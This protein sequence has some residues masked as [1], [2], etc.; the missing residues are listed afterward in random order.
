MKNI[1]V[2]ASGGNVTHTNNHLCCAE[3]RVI[4]ELEYNAKKSGHKGKKKGVWIRR[5]TGGVI[6]VWRFSSDGQYANAF[7]CKVCMKSIVNYGLKLQCS[8]GPDLWYKGICPPRG[9]NT[10]EDVASLDVP[11]SKLTN[12][13]R[14]YFEG[15]RCKGL[16]SLE[17]P[18]L[19]GLHR[20]RADDLKRTAYPL[21]LKYH[22]G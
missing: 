6:R 1:I 19:H 4:S 11:S 22:V 18:S 20:Y 16:S 15:L 21:N 13:Q 2:Y 9:G 10:E 8:I 17:K 3:R 7:P 12:G 14:F 5:V